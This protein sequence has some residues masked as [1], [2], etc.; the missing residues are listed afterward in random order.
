MRTAVAHET[1]RSPNKCEFKFTPAYYATVIRSQISRRYQVLGATQ[2]KQPI[3]TFTDD[4]VSELVP[5]S[6]ANS[7]Q[8]LRTVQPSTDSALQTQH[9]LKKRHAKQVKQC[10][11]G[12]ATRLT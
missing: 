8:A 6:K 7:V 12:K 1:D 4:A 3:E 2:L 11:S 10:Q 5:Q 9:H